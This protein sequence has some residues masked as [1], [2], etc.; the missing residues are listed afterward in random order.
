M[1]VNYQV[2]RASGSLVKIPADHGR[3]W[4]EGFHMSR[5]AFCREP[6]LTS[7]LRDK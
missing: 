3:D 7:C 6:G 4:G 5:N 2:R 1:T